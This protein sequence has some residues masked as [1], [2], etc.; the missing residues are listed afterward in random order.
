MYNQSFSILIN[1]ATDSG[2]GI[3][4]KSFRGGAEIHKHEHPRYDPEEPRSSDAVYEQYNTISR[5]RRYPSSPDRGS[6][7]LCSQIDETASDSTIFPETNHSGSRE[8]AIPIAA[9]NFHQSPIGE[10][11]IIRSIQRRK[12]KTN[13]QNICLAEAS[14]TSSRPAAIL[15]N[16]NENARSKAETHSAQ[17]SSENTINII[18]AEVYSR[19]PSEFIKS[20]EEPAETQTTCDLPVSIGECVREDIMALDTQQT[21]RM[22]RDQSSSSSSDYH[23]SE[24]EHNGSDS[25]S[26]ELCDRLDDV[27]IY[28]EQIITPI[29]DP[30]RQATVDRIMDEFWVIFNQRWPL[31]VRQHGTDS[32]QES[33]PLRSTITLRNTAQSRT[34]QRRRQREDDGDDP[35]RGSDRSHQPPSQSTAP[36]D[37]PADRPRFACLFRKHDPCRY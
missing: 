36:E 35:D 30:A 21:E 19:T 16:L 13:I 10:G 34:S 1:T 6:G 14:L 23:S 5:P 4:I 31:H 8:S 18:N 17:G 28:R 32:N 25:I 29:L 11:T 15:A 20:S 27:H 24:S 26:N 33:G 12:S 3:S 22:D 9:F 2:Y 37:G 7:V